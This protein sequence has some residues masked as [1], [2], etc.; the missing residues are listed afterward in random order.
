MAVI[1][2]LSSIPRFPEPPAPLW[3]VSDK[4]VHVLLYAG[5]AALIVRALS[6][7]WLRAFAVNT[8][9]V[10]VAIAIGY[11]ITDEIHQHF[12]PQRTMD[13]AD[14]IADAVGSVLAVGSLYLAGRQRI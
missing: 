11:G 2:V 8:A 9:C 14:V 13:G 7:G 5:L 6:G 10:A 12:V 4:G 3:F 1:F